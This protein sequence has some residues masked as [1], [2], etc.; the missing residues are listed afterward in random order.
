MFHKLHSCLAAGK[1][2][3]PGHLHGPPTPCKFRTQ[4]LDQAPLLVS[5]S[6]N[7]NGDASSARCARL[8]CVAVASQQR[9]AGGDRPTEIWV[10]DGEAHGPVTTPRQATEDV[11]GLDRTAGHPPAESPSPQD[12]GCPPS[13]SE[14]QSAKQEG[15]RLA[16]SAA[17]AVSSNAVEPEG[18]GCSDAG[19]HGGGR[20]ATQRRPVTAQGKRL[21]KETPA[22]Q[23]QHLCATAEA[24]D[25]RSA[26]EEPLGSQRSWDGGAAPAAAAAAG[27]SAAPASEPL[28]ALR[29]PRHRPTRKEGH[30]N[31]EQQR[32]RQQPAAG[33]AS[34]AQAAG[35]GTC[36]AGGGA[37]AA[38]AASITAAGEAAAPNA[39]S[40][41]AVSGT[42]ACEE[43]PL[44]PASVPAPA[45][46]LAPQGATEEVGPTAQ[47][48]GPAA[49][50]SPQSVRPGPGPGP[51]LAPAASVYVF[52]DLDNKY[53]E[54]LDH[55]GMLGRLRDMLQ[56]YG[57]VVE[58]RAYGNHRTFKFVPEVWE[59]AMRHGVMKHP[60][61]GSPTAGGGPSSSSSS[62]LSAS[63]SA[64][65]SSSSEGLRCP[66]CSRRVRGGESQLR[67][68]FR[69]MHQREHVKKLARMGAAERAEY[70]QSRKSE[71]Y[72]SAAHEVLAPKRGY[73]LAGI[74]RRLGVTVWAVPMGKQKA[75]VVLQ[76]EA[77]ELLEGERGKRA[78][79]EVGG[80]KERKKKEAE[81][82]PSVFVLM[83]DDHG[84]EML[85]KLFTMAGWR[86]L[87]V[88][89]TRF[90]NADERLPWSNVLPPPLPPPPLP[91]LPPPPPLLQRDADARGPS[92]TGAGGMV[93][94]GCSWTLMRR[95]LNSRVT[96]QKTRTTPEPVAEGDHGVE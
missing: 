92:R 19:H 59:A 72:R 27:A 22:E 66:L 33:L 26:D 43:A 76:R 75:D 58:I 12:A 70:V 88:S 86:A 3:L 21:K 82:P 56:Q 16:A 47:Q 15:Q 46:I 74:L 44:G 10:G 2:A 9:S 48:P 30:N 28:G 41:A 24:V 53:P 69:Q 96:P 40:S 51:A 78:D 93:R 45:A 71:R 57:R 32:R 68:H 62:S 25:E 73:D 77:V 42:A 4:H 89:N 38:G 31:H 87:V 35:V 5:V 91:P 79:L 6:G 36:A 95:L 34:P 1:P 83:S 14:T 81:K 61:R 60:L 17:A 50:Q 39:A 49:P 90:R 65:S 67:S 85:L 20:P 37:A 64:G 23:R 63:S 84:F 29:H 8:R 18:G 7:R 11:L 54:T 80:E 55:A 52:W 94:D 13:C